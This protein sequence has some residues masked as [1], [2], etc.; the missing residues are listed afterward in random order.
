MGFRS[1]RSVAAMHAAAAAGRVALLRELLY[2][3]YQEQLSAQQLRGQVLAAGPTVPPPAAAL[4]GGH[5]FA[6]PSEDHYE[7]LSEAAAMAAAEA[8][9]LECLRAAVHRASQGVHRAVLLAAARAGHASVVRWLVVH[10]PPPLLPRGG[11]TPLAQRRAATAL[12]V[13][14]VESG[15]LELVVQWLAEEKGAR[16]GLGPDV[17]AAGRRRCAAAAASWWLG[18]PHS[19]LA[20]MRG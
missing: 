5:G 16:R 2:S 1:T 13:A 7:A 3:S 11:P 9:Q 19:S 6:G 10:Y 15:S 14:A 12:L 8:G 4:G 20:A 18:W 17:M